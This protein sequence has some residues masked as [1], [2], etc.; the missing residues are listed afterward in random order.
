M[1]KRKLSL[2]KTTEHR[3]YTT[4]FVVSRFRRGRGQP[5]ASDA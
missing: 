1:N 2:K 3:S 4:G 5:D